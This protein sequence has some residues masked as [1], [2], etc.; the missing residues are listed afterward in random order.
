[1]IAQIRGDEMSK[2][3]LKVQSRLVLSPDRSVEM[4]K[5]G[6]WFWVLHG[7]WGVTSKGC[8]GEGIPRDIQVFKSFDEAERFGK[9]WRGH[10]WYC[11]PNGT[12]EVIEM[13]ENTKI[14]ICGWKRV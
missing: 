4:T 1:M 8:R 9:N 12:C 11:R 14:V 2:F 10:P 13:E 5:A 7:E 3:A 6:E